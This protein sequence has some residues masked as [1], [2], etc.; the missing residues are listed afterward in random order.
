MANWEKRSPRRNALTT[1][2]SHAGWRCALGSRSLVGRWSAPS[3]SWRRSSS[4]GSAESSGTRWRAPERPA[5]RLAPRS[6]STP[7]RAGSWRVS[8][9]SGRAGS[10]RGAAR[11]KPRPNGNS[12]KSSRLGDS[13]QS[14]RR[15][16]EE[17]NPCQL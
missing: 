15:R 6:S 3:S 7:W 8:S 14:P 2:F 11:G 5:T 10:R 9:E 1:S 12:T 4:T 17:R 16:S 13:P